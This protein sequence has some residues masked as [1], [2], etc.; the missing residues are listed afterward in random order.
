MSRRREPPA[1]R[2]SI[3]RTP[4]AYMISLLRTPV[5]TREGFAR[6][7]DVQ[8]LELVPACDGKVE[9]E[10]LPVPRESPL[11]PGEAV[12]CESWRRVAARVVRTGAPW[13]LVFEDDAE[14]LRPLDSL[15]ADIS[16]VP[17]GWDFIKL[18]DSA[19][20]EP[21]TLCEG[22]VFHQVAQCSWVTAAVAMSMAGAC[23]VTSQPPLSPRSIERPDGT[24]HLRTVS[25]AQAV[26]NRRA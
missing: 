20:P 4:P 13:A 14:P 24:Q 11:Q 16:A 15:V 3:H 17:A 23:K 10:N 9:L 25:P 2:P 7:R 1:Q 12:L 21:V 8:N 6:L 26:Q 5:R 19:R 22:A 18:D